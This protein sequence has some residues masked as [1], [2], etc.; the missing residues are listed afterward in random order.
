MSTRNQPT[1]NKNSFKSLHFAKFFKKKRT[2]T[3]LNIRKTYAYLYINRLINITC[4][5]CIRINKM[6]RSEFS[7]SSSIRENSMKSEQIHSK[8]SSLTI[9]DGA[10]ILL[11]S[12]FVWKCQKQSQICE[13]QKK[14][15]IQNGTKRKAT[16]KQRKHEKTKQ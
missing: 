1:N 4:I 14:Q 11:T 3:V 16:V 8:L 13:D 9:K 6:L 10:S 5:S 2:K 12:K 7:F 15:E